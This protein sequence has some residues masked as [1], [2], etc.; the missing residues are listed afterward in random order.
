M[1]SIKFYPVGNGDTS[2]IILDNGRRILMDFRHQKN[3]ED[4]KSPVI[5]LAATLRQELKDADKDHFDVVAFTH[6]DLDISRIAMNFSNC[7]VLVK[8]TPGAT[9][10]KSRKFGCPVRCYSRW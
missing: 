4:D 3:G 6:A 10:S 7:P 2:Q 8:S 5:D 9:V 1:A